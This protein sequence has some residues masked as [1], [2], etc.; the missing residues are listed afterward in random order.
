MARAYLKV[1]ADLTK[2]T[3]EREETVKNPGT[4][5]AQRIIMNFPIAETIETLKVPPIQSRDPGKLKAR[6]ATIDG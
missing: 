6:M 2:Q 4:T 5:K 1:E 3:V